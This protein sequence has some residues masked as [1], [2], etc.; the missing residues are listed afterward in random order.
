MEDKELKL[1]EEKAELEEVAIAE[2]LSPEKDVEETSTEP[3]EEAPADQKKKKGPQILLAKIKNCKGLNLRANPS[4]E[5][6]ILEVLRPDNTFSINKKASTQDFYS[7]EFEALPG[8]HISG[9][10]LK[11]FIE[12]ISK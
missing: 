6:P 9:F 8:K 5:A 4:L 12:I 10:A 2:E 1:E 3:V 11:E 7:V